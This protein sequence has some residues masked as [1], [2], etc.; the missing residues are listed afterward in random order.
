MWACPLPLPL[1]HTRARTHACARYLYNENMG[2]LLPLWTASWQAV[3]FMWGNWFM[4]VGSGWQLPAPVAI[5]F[6]V[7]DQWAVC[8]VTKKSKAIPV[9]GHGGP[10]V[11]ERSRL[12]YFPDNRLTDGGKVVSP[13]CWLP[14][15]YT[16]P[17]EGSWYSFLLEAE[18]TPGPHSAAGRIRSVEKSNDLNGNGTTTSQLIA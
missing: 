2:Q 15:L 13:T 12:P 3:Q 11:C 6:S 7:T 17:Q 18:S 14:S 9:T 16:P 5:L 8:Y 10:W 4:I 1:S